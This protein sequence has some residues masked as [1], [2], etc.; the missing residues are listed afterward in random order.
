MLT[1][2]NSKDVNGRHPGL[3]VCFVTL[4]L[5]LGVTTVWGGGSTVS[6]SLGQ[7]CLSVGKKPACLSV[8][9]SSLHSAASDPDILF[10]QHSVGC[11]RCGCE[12]HHQDTVR[13]RKT[14]T[15]VRCDASLCLGS[16]EGPMQ[17]WALPQ[18]NASYGWTLCPVPRL[19]PTCCLFPNSDHATS[20]ERSQDAEFCPAFHTKG[21][22]FGNK[23]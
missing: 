17:P 1:M 8:L 3:P 23:K 14:I 11:W 15:W 9:H 6:V 2:G 4:V 19:C 12:R 22:K 7:D 13:S 10:V 21:P 18:Y 16:T 20:F 5:G